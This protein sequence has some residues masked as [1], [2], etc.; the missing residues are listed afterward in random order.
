MIFSIVYNNGIIIY[1]FIWR[2][3]L[4]HQIVRSA[5]TGYQ[6]SIINIRFYIM[7]LG[8]LNSL[9]ANIFSNCFFFL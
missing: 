4:N 3:V 5:I 8:I 7:L 1:Q 2:L 9:T 6:S